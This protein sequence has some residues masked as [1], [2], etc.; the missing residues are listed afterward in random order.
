MIYPDDDE[1]QINERVEKMKA[2]RQ[3]MQQERMMNPYGIG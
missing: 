3:Q 2:K 1:R